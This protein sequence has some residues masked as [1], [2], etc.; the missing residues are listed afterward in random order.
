VEEVIGPRDLDSLCNMQALDLFATPRAREL[1]R[2]ASERERDAEVNW[3]ERE[4]EYG[5]PRLEELP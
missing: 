1:T 3:E 4:M 5:I 2:Q